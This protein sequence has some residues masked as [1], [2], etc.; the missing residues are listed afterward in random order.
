M[1]DLKKPCGAR[2]LLPGE[3]KKIDILFNVGGESG[4]KGADFAIS[5]NRACR[6]R[7]GGVDPPGGPGG[8]ARGAGRV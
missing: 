2:V 5:I 6:A 4:E 7:G 3:L 8:R 1:Q